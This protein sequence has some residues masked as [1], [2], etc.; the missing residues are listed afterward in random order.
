MITDDS[1]KPVS[2]A[3]RVDV[4]TFKIWLKQGS[5]NANAFGRGYITKSTPFTTPPNEVRITLSRAGTLV[6]RAKS[7]QQMRLDQQNGT[8][9]RPLPPIHEGINGPF[10]S[11]APGSYLLSTIA[12]DRTVLRS[13]PVMIEAGQTVTIDV[14]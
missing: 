5:Y 8:M 2:Q 12:A 11:I 7:A 9:R 13:V 4:G 3:Q 6:I 1:R 10:E 14:P